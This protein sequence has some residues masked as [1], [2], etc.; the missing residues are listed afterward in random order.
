M[1]KTIRQL[2][3]LLV[4]FVAAIMMVTRP[5]RAADVFLDTATNPA[6]LRD[7]H[8]VAVGGNRVG[9]AN[10]SDGQNTGISYDYSFVASNIWNNEHNQVLAGVQYGRREFDRKLALPDGFAMPDRMDNAAA[11]IVY[12]HITSGDW[13][14]SQSVRCNRS[15]TDSPSVTIRDTFDIVG[16]AVISRKPG[17]A[18]AFGYAYIQTD[19]TKDRIYPVIEYMNNAHERWAITLG[20]P[21]LNFG[22][23]PHPDLALSGGGISYK[24]TEQNIV[25]LSYAGDQWAYRLEGPD[26]KAVAYTAQRAGL[27]WTYIYIIDRRTGVVLNAALGWE[28]KRKL[29]S[30]DKNNKLSLGD[31]AVMGL[32]ASLGF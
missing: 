2:M 20:Y 14:I 19:T 25:R 26:V 13:S 32:N 31:A 6:F 17:V 29:G 22:F 30:D 11:A 8:V 15:W 16:L 5:A 27:D 18:W 24:V 23:S 21:V 1:T 10:T 28:F 7:V 9:S 4:C 3:P 12:K